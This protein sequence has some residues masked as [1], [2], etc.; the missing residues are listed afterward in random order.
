MLLNIVK[1]LLVKNQTKDE[2]MAIFWFEG[3]SL[4]VIVPQ[5]QGNS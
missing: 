4:C 3:V 1:A 2:N 5:L